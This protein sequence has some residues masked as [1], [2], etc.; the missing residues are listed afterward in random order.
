MKNYMRYFSVMALATLA[1]L[2]PQFAHASSPDGLGAKLCYVY[3]CYVNSDL[4]IIIATMAI[5]FLGIGAFFGKVNWGLVIIVV[6]GIVV[7]T[8]AM[9]IATKVIGSSGG[10]VAPECKPDY[11]ATC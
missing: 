4:M 7:T 10:T 3:A 6:L 1:A 9:A 5:L 2:M 11:A 8:G